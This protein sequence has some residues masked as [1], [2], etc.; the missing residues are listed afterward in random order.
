MSLGYGIC[1]QSNGLTYEGEWLNNQRHGYGVT[2]YPDGSK[3]EGKYKYNAITSG[4]RRKNFAMKS[5]RIRTKV[6][7]AIDRAQK[8][9]ETA[10]Q[11]VDITS[12]R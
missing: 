4:A 3:E 10:I 7:H 2:T 1:K 5:N 11:K 12:S 8:A 9:K 6:A